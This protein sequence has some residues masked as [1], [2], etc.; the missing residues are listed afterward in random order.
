MIR[1]L[2]MLALALSLRLVLPL[3]C[4]RKVDPV[5]EARAAIT[6]AGRAQAIKA[7]NIHLLTEGDTRNRVWSFREVPR[8]AA[9]VANL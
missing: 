3:T 7:V 8:C 1:L 2:L 5:V 9:S 4:W 6:A